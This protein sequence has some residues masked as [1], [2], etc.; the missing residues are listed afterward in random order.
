MW[1]DSVLISQ[2]SPNMIFKSR[3][4]RLVGAPSEELGCSA[5][6]ALRT[7]F[8]HDMRNP[9]NLLRWP[10]LVL[11]VDYLLPQTKSIISAGICWSE[12]VILNRNSNFQAQN[13]GYIRAPYHAMARVGS[14]P[15]GRR[16]LKIYYDSCSMD[17]VTSCLPTLT[18]VPSSR[19]Q[20]QQIAGAVNEKTAKT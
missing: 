15:L 9:L 10:V 12:V 7:L 18:A 16:A 14:A 5:G 13:S 20:P 1:T 8:I 4:H 19:G 6:F 2:C 3:S 17:Q 11:Y